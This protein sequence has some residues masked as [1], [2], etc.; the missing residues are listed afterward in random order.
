MQVARVNVQSKVAVGEG[1]STGW[2][3]TG[4]YAS[5]QSPVSIM[6]VWI[7]TFVSGFNKRAHLPLFSI[8]S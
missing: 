3:E 4:S 8:L 7:Y 1:M 5:L 6:K 2:T